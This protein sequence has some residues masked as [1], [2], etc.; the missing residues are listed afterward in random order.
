MD[1]HGRGVWDVLGHGLLDR[2][3]GVSDIKHGLDECYF[4]TCESLSLSQPEPMMKATNWP[5]SNQP[6]DSSGHMPRKLSTSSRVRGHS[7]DTDTNAG[8]GDRVEVRKVVT[9]F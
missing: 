3:D 1:V 6:R 2:R 8:R 4:P 7:P 5:S 9:H